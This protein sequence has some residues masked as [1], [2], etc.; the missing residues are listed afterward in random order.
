[1]LNPVSDLRLIG[2]KSLRKLIMILIFLD[3]DRV[4]LSGYVNFQLQSQTFAKYGVTSDNASRDIKAKVWVELFDKEAVKHLHAF[5]IHL[6][7]FDKV[8]IVISSDW[9][10]GRNVQ[11]LKELF[12]PY[13]FSSRII[14][15]TIDEI[16]YLTLDNER[17]NYHGE[18]TGRL[19]RGEEIEIWLR[20]NQEIIDIQCHF[21][22]DDDNRADQLSELFP[23]SFIHCQD[24]VLQENDVKKALELFEQGKTGL[25]KKQSCDISAELV[26]RANILFYEVS[27]SSLSWEPKGPPTEMTLRLQEERRLAFIYRFLKNESPLFFEDT[28]YPEKIQYEKQRRRNRCVDLIMEYSMDPEKKS[29]IKNNMEFS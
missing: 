20:T 28:D 11:Q 24:G 12:Q 14:G 3:I 26:H 23:N 29:T 16:G 15:K 10:R 18:P 2:T 1:M 9:R 17:L 13:E 25:E 22:F 19:G 21:I 27:G 6:E 5:I 8:G 4:L 7:K